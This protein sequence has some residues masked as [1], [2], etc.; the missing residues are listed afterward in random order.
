MRPAREGQ[1]IGYCVGGTL[2]GL[3][4]PGWRRRTT[5][6]SNA[7]T[8]FTTQVDFTQAGDLK[9]FVDEEQVASGSK[10]A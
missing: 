7:A 6:A 2:L 1:R 9:V 8:F 5:S 10:G 4:R 3:A